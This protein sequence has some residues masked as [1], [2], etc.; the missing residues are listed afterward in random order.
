MCPIPLVL[1]PFPSFSLPSF[2]YF[3]RPPILPTS[4]PFILPPSL[5]P[6][7][8]TKP[9]STAGSDRRFLC[10][11]FPQSPFFFTG[12]PVVGLQSPGRNFLR[13]GAKLAHCTYYGETVEQLLAFGHANLGS[14]AWVSISA[15]HFSFFGITTE[16]PKIT[17]IH[18]SHGFC[19]V[20]CIW[21]CGSNSLSRSQ[22]Q[23]RT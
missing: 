5:P 7:L 21:G 14:R 4:L 19:N 17:A 2:V 13:L 15:G 20:I 22:Y 8:P 11:V 6:C 1:P 10:C 16:W 9:S 23:E 18:C 12:K 3:P